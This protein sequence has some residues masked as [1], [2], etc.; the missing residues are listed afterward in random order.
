M[1]TVK[2]IDGTETDSASE[3]W[4]HESEA[5]WVTARPTLDERR[6][7]LHSV[8]QSRGKTEADRLRTTMGLIWDAKKKTK[9]EGTQK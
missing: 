5:R 7:Y 4:R 2:L 1:T 8:E 3:A 6:A 9:P